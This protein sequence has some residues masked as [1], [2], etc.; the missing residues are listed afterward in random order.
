MA[1]H[2]EATVKQTNTQ[3]K[4]QKSAA[5]HKAGPTLRI[6]QKNTED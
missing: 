5:K 4:K 1:N 3:L 6:T 2:E